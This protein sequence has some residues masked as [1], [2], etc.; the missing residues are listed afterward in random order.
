[1]VPLGAANAISDAICTNM[2]GKWNLN[3]INGLSKLTPGR[4]LAQKNGDVAI[5]RILYN[6]LATLR[7]PHFGNL[8]HLGHANVESHSLS[9]WLGGMFSSAARSFE[10]CCCARCKQLEIR[11]C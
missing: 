1:M 3:R 8:R 6:T 9:L 4:D 5:L 2:G 11:F 7:A 10:N